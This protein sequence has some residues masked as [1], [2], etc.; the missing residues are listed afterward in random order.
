MKPNKPVRNII[1]AFDERGSSVHQTGLCQS[2]FYQNPLASNICTPSW[3]AAFHHIRW[4]PPKHIV[5]MKAEVCFMWEKQWNCEDKKKK[6][7]ISHL[8]VWKCLMHLSHHF[9]FCFKNIVSVKVDWW[10]S[11]PGCEIMMLWDSWEVGNHRFGLLCQY[12][13]DLGTRVTLFH[14][15]LLNETLFLQLSANHMKQEFSISSF[16]KA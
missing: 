15:S 12:W 8:T 14:I 16:V 7:V 11:F 2:M 5:N 13:D 3:V 10:V 1:G 9:H 4:S 6:S